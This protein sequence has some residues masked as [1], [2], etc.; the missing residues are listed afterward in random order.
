MSSFWLE[1]CHVENL[2]LKFT[3]KD[4]MGAKKHQNLTADDADL[5]DES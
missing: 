4:A 2:G 3:A 5:T 1:V